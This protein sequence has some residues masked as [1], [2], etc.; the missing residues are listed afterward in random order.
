LTAGCASL[1]AG[2]VVAGMLSGAAPSAKVLAQYPAAPADG[3][4]GF[5][6]TEFW[7]AVH[8]GKEDCPEGLAG[9]VRENYLASLPQAERTRLMLKENE[10][11]LTRKWK[12]SALGPDNTNLCTN[13]DAFPGRPLQKTVKGKIAYGL[14]MDG[15]TSGHP[16]GG[17]AHAQFTGADGEQGIDNQAYRALGCTRNWRG[18]DGVAGDIKGFNNFLA[19]GEHTMVLRLRGVKSLK[20]S[21]DV[22]VILA[23]TDDRPVL[24]SH[25][26]FV[27][28]A[29][30]TISRPQWRNV[31]HGRIHDGVLTTDPV[32]VRLNRRLGH[33]GVR[34]ARSEYDL[35]QARLR[36]TLRADGTVEGLLGAYQTPANLV[37]STSLGGIGAAVVA[38]IDCSAEYR[39]LMALADGLKNPATG[40]CTGVSNAYRVVAVP[41]FVNDL[42]ASAKSAGRP[43]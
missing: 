43:L 10:P 31:M 4:M 8:Q 16:A 23:S 39:T 15:D 42:P 40:Q 37:E 26:N 34:G 38:G 14:N 2:V 33:G 1:A 17:C 24:D 27:T 6:L 7:P 18:I 5:V 36:L 32:D 19:T 12:A 11:E 20:D 30:F 9:T 3:E 35:R 28:G 41:A 22:E 29:S 25:R 21:P 13:P